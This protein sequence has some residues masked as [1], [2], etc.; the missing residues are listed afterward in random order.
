MI[1]R[2]LNL[3]NTDNDSI[4]VWGARQ[5]G[6]TTLI[7]AI[8]PDAVNYDLLQAKD[9]ERLQRNPSLLGEDLSILNSGDTV[10]IDE[11]QKIPQLLDE[12]EGF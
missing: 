2:I 7:R 1:N 6:K 12:V 8:Y 9:F 5:V 4:F 11:I 3:D 10:I